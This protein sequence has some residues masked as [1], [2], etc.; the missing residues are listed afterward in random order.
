MAK[1]VW[2]YHSLICH[3]HTAILLDILV[4]LLCTCL[5][6]LPALLAR[7]HAHE[8]MRSIP[9]WRDS[10]CS[11]RVVLEKQVNKN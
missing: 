1:G 7:R 6:N 11:Q 8:S 10:R 5:G 3:I 2:K 4:S 9:L